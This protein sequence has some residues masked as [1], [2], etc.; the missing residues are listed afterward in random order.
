MLGIE[1]VL[2][3]IVDTLNYY[4]WGY[5]LI[6]LLI[7]VGLFFTVRLK[8]I[9]VRQFGHIL[10]LM[11]GSRK[12][13]DGQISSFQAFCMSLGSR[14]GAGN[15]A[16]VAVAIYLGGPGA[17]F[18]M[19][20]LAVIGMATAFSEATLAQLY[21]QKSGST[22]FVGGPAYYIEKGLKNRFLGVCFAVSLIIAFGFVFNAVQANTMVLA[23][24]EAFGVQKEILAIVIAVATALIIG[25]GI[26][27]ISKFCEVAVPIMALLY[28]VLAVVII[29]MNLSKVPEVFVLIFHSAFGLETA[30]AGVLGFTIGAAI[31]NGIKRGLF[32]NE[33]GMGSAA[34]AA[35]TASPLPKHP[36]AQGYIQ[37][38]SVFTDTLVICTITAL[39]VLLSGVFEPNSNVTGIALAQ[40]ALAS[41]IG[42]SGSW[43]L[44][45]ILIF[46]AF[47]SIVANYSYAENNILYITKSRLV[48][49]IMR[50]C[51]ILFVLFGSLTQVALVW[52]MADVAMGV[53]AIINLIAILLLSKKVLAVVQ[54]YQRQLK[55]G[56]EIVFQSNDYD[57]WK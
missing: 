45:V 19:W 33:A 36:A 21:K 11:F 57:A 9:Q 1:S 29:G 50:G 10:K 38:F 32:S 8:L 27:R 43:V 51:V 14:V 3:F 42:A 2:S 7:A 26:W 31:E 52:N 25:G 22:F 16:G 44:A 24:N 53:M 55:S 34:N 12:S 17:I 47:T 18:W 30:G 6:Y 48:L 20:L 49:N 13:R 46:F 41:Q 15:I 28:L 4:L 56:K 5:V 54:D 40:S 37:M 39:I 35:A 23:V